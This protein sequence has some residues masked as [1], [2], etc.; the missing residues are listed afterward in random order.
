MWRRRKG[1][2]KRNA[3]LGRAEW[4]VGG[5]RGVSVQCV[6]GLYRKIKDV[7]VSLLMK[8]CFPTV[9]TPL[10]PT[11]YLTV[12]RRV[13]EKQAGRGGKFIVKEEIALFF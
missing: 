12:E 4:D 1:G 2:C 13:M 11:A 9:F 3:G 7:Y 10:G 6:C 5:K 8:V